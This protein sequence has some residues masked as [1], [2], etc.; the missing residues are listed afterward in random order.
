[1]HKKIDIQDLDIPKN[2]LEC[3]ERYPKH[4]WVYDLSRLLDAQHIKWSPFRT[5]LLQNKSINMKFN[6]IF[7]ESGVIFSNITSNNQ[8]VSEVYIIKGEIKNICIRDKNT[9]EIITESIGDVEL[10]I[11]AFVSMYFQKFNGVIS[12]ITYGNEIY[13]ICLRPISDLDLI[14]DSELI[15]L[16][17]RIYKKSDLVH[18]IG[19]TDHSLHE[20]L[21]S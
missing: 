10:R 14:T 20:M 17:K 12:V 4:R 6:N 1:M 11:N 19:P 9:N 8:Y 13:S 21:I 7:L 15:R 5:E 2:D 18:I 16:I 3:W